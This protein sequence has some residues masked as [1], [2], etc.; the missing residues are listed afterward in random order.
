MS[1]HV[2]KMTPRILVILILI[3]HGYANTMI[4]KMIP[5]IANTFFR[6]KI[7]NL[8]YCFQKSKF[9][10]QTSKHSLSNLKHEPTTPSYK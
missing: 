8:K 9:K 6:Q 7:Q 2:E 5:E 1:A 10:A 3:L 4:L